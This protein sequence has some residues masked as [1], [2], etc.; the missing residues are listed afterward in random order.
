MHHGT[1]DDQ[2]RSRTNPV[3]QNVPLVDENLLVQ[4]SQ[5]D[6]QALGTLYDLYG[7]FVYKTALMITHDRTAA[8]T[9]VL[10][11]FHA[12]WLSAG[13][14]PRD[15]SVPVWLIGMARKQATYI[16]KHVLQGQ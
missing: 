15:T 12:V 6:E 1:A 10:N 9:V 13:S 8:E 2:A 3:S 14:F 4:I 11:V 5:C 16:T 7:T